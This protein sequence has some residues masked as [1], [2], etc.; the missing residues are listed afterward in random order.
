MPSRLERRTVFANV[1]I[2]RASEDICPGVFMVAG[3]G[4]T[5]VVETA[6]GLVVVDVPAG[7]SA[8][9]LE[10]IRAKTNAPI[11]TIIYTHIHGDHA[12]T[13]AA[14]LEDAR[15]RGDR[16]PTVIAQ[17]RSLAHLARYK[18]M[19]PYNWYI[20]QIQSGRGFAKPTGKARFLPENVVYP[21]VTFREAMSFKLGGLTFE[22]YHYLGETDDGTCD[23]KCP[24]GQICCEFVCYTESGGGDSGIVIDGGGGNDAG[25]GTDGGGGCQTDAD[26]PQG[27]TCLMG[28]C[29]GM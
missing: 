7:G 25:G 22:L 23:P 11:N 13:T 29:F 14:L 16:K 17:E 8:G 1:M 26:C 15:K 4:N 9:L 12:F 28:M 2:A 19:E 20:N 6:E 18:E 24:S 27:Q 21:D 10:A 3:F 5:T